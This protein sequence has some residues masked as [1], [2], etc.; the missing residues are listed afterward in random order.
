MYPVVYQNHIFCPICKRYYRHNLMG[1]HWKRCKMNYQLYLQNIKKYNM[2]HQTRPNTVRQPPRNTVR[3]PPRNTVRQT[4]RNTVQQPFRNTIRQPPRNTVQQPPRNTVRQP[5]RNTV[6]QPTINTVR[7]PPRNTVQQPLRNTVNKNI[8]PVSENKLSIVPYN[9]PTKKVKKKKKKKKTTTLIKRVPH[10]T[11]EYFI[12]QY[13][14]LYSDYLSGKNVAIIGPAKSIQG[15][16]LGSMIDKFDIIVRI[17]KA[18]PIPERLKIDI[19][20]RTDILYNSLNTT[21]Y[22]GENNINVN[23]LKS[24]GVKF[25]CC[26]YP[27]NGVFQNDITMFIKNSQFQIPF[28]SVNYRH[29]IEAQNMMKTRPYSG[30]M[31]IIDLLKF[32][33]NMLYVTGIDFYMTPYYNE[34]R[35]ISKKKLNGIRDNNIH[36]NLPQINYLRILSLTDKRVVVDNLLKGILFKN[37]IKLVKKLMKIQINNVFKIESKSIETIFNKS[38]LKYLIIGS[39]YLD[40]HSIKS[41]LSE[42]DII[43]NLNNNSIDANNVITIGKINRSGIGAISFYPKVKNEDNNDFNIYPYKNYLIL[44]KSLFKKLK[45]KN[46]GIDMILLLQLLSLTK[47]NNITITNINIKKDPEEKLLLNYLIKYKYYNEL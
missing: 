42:Y 40:Y 2:M 4:P 45:I 22:P 37:Y 43:I 15:T 36:K 23:F 17:N 28:R 14:G 21:D 31:A 39:S 7:Q 25:V 26:P 19:G 11:I 34:Y 10:N 20:S 6:Q 5:P 35:I 3:Q 27:N 33:I 24:N 47:N 38:N 1:I 9:K 32:N 44:I 13:T 30:T 29:F 16:S 41:R 8:I 18:L 12:E 46:G